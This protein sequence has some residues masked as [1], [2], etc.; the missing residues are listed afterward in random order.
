MNK[1]PYI[2]PTEEEAKKLV[3]KMIEA[4]VLFAN[5]KITFDQLWYRVRGDRRFMAVQ[6]IKDGAFGVLLFYLCL[7]FI[8]WKGDRDDIIMESAIRVAVD[9]EAKKNMH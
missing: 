1:Y 7:D 6:K 8:S 2:N 5:R 9:V 3:E 4:C